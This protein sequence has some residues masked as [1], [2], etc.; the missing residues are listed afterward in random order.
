MNEKDT[1]VELKEKVL[2]LFGSTIP[3][4]NIIWELFP[5]YCKLKLSH[6]KIISGGIKTNENGN[7]IKITFFIINLL[8][9]E[10]IVK[11]TAVLNTISKSSSDKWDSY[12]YSYQPVITIDE[13]YNLLKYIFTSKN[14]TKE[15]LADKNIVRFDIF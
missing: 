11:I 4:N 8:S 15:Y 1:K 13:G 7:E 12:Q 5:N 10:D 6:L 2:E 3:A 9:L 14:H